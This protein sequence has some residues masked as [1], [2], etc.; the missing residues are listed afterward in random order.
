[1]CISLLECLAE[2]PP[3]KFKSPDDVAVS[4]ANEYW[5]RFF[6]EFVERNGV[7]AVSE[8]T[9]TSKVTLYV[10]LLKTQFAL[11]LLCIQM[12]QEG[13]FNFSNWTHEQRLKRPV[14]ASPL[15]ACSRIDQRDAIV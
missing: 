14:Y 7:E 8:S 12:Q 15:G 5:M 9:L 11:I 10:F 1:M 13:N 4:L 3:I 2:L 6:I